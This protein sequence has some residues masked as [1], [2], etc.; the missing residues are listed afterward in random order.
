M[1]SDINTI[2]PALY[3]YHALPTSYNDSTYM[4]CI[5][6]HLAMLQYKQVE[7]NTQPPTAELIT[8]HPLTI[9]CWTTGYES[10]S[11]LKARSLSTSAFRQCIHSFIHSFIDSWFRTA[12]KK[13]L[14]KKNTK[15]FQTIPKKL[16]NIALIRG[17]QEPSKFCLYLFAF[18]HKSPNTFLNTT[19]LKFNLPISHSVLI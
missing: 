6:L 7:Q 15:Q 9:S 4:V 3:T 8:D 19:L 2:L 18:S 16:H 1:L 17:I 5:L 12:G 14:F 13:F 10:F 11:L